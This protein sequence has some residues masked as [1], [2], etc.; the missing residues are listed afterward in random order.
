MEKVVIY[1]I[2]ISPA[3]KEG[4]EKGYPCKCRLP[5]GEFGYVEVVDEEDN[6]ILKV[7]Q[8]HEYDITDFITSGLLSNGDEV[9]ILDNGRYG[10]LKLPL[11]R[12]IMKLRKALF[13]YN[14]KL[15]EDRIHLGV[16]YELEFSPNLIQ[17]MYRRLVGL[18]INRRRIDPTKLRKS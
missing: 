16:A 15:H 9:D 2:K 17:R 1:K 14:L 10:R 4:F 3:P 6:I 5:N 7:C 18:P 11:K 12:E 8:I 13:K